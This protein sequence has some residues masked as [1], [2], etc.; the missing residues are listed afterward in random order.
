MKK[1]IIL[2]L[3]IITTALLIFLTGCDVIDIISNT[4]INEDNSNIDEGDSNTDKQTEEAGMGETTQNNLTNKTNTTKDNT[5]N[6]NKTSKNNTTNQANTSKNNTTSKTNT[7]KNNTTNS[8]TAKNTDKSSSTK[9][10]LDMPENVKI[11]YEHY[12][13]E[14]DQGWIIE[15]I[16][17]GNNA[18]R[19][20]VTTHGKDM[21][22]YSNYA[23]HYYKYKGNGKWNDYYSTN[24]KPW[25][26]YREDIDLEAVDAMVNVALRKVELP[27]NAKTIGHETLHVDGLGDIDTDIITITDK[28][29]TTTTINYY[30]KIGLYV[31]S[32]EDKHNTTFTI[33]EYDTSV[34]SFERSIP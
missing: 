32:I 16:K 15:V 31:K 29:N 11:H 33:K 20:D 30:K 22:P 13:P 25:T 4:I 14:T 9:D 24:S 34:K 10:K 17:I 3:I 6:K 8:S 21:T 2:V 19:T 18:F 27:E 26:L 7:T 5:T 28:T 23:Y 12:M 1:S